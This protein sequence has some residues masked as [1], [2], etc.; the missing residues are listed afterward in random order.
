MVGLSLHGSYS[1]LDEE[2]PIDHFRLVVRVLEREVKLGVVR[3]LEVQEDRGGFPDVDRS[4]GVSRTRV[5][6][7]GDAAIGVDLR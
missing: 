1:S 4:L 6:E 5:D 7:G 3:L 2:D